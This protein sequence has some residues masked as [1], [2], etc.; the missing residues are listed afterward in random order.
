MTRWRRVLPAIVARFA[1][2]MLPKPALP[3]EVVAR[4]YHMARVRIEAHRLDDER[5]RWDVER[6]RKR[7]AIVDRIV[8]GYSRSR[9]RRLSRQEL[10]AG[11][12]VLH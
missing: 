1:A 10:G 3:A 6:R 8:Q 4:A 2:H 5:D 7:Q 11:R 9:G 12:P